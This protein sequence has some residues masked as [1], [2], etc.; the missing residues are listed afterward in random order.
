MTKNEVATHAIKKLTTVSEQFLINAKIAE[1]TGETV[2]YD[3]E[4]NCHGF[5]S[6]FNF[7]NPNT[8]MV[9][10]SGSSFALNPH[11]DDSFFVNHMHKIDSLK[12]DKDHLNKEYLTTIENIT[13]KGETFNISFI[14]AYLL[15]LEKTTNVNYSQKL[16]NLI[17]LNS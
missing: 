2:V 8:I 7:M 4:K 3:I 13:C 5:H 15:Y 12:M 10:R 11:L 1:L 14:K 6:T 16:L 9:T 17:R